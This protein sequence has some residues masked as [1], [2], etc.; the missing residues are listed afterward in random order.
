MEGY[1]K[2]DLAFSGLSAINAQA[3]V[4]LDLLIEHSMKNALVG[5]VGSKH[6][7]KVHG[8]KT[9]VHVR[10][11]KDWEMIKSHLVE[12]QN[13]QSQGGISGQVLVFLL[14]KLNTSS[15]VMSEVVL[16]DKVNTVY[17]YT[18]ILVENT[19]Y[20]VVVEV[21]VDNMDLHIEH[22]GVDMVVTDYTSEHTGHKH[23]PKFSRKRYGRV[24]SPYKYERI[25]RV[26]STRLWFKFYNFAFLKDF[27]IY[28]RVPLPNI[29]FEGVRTRDGWYMCVMP[30]DMAPMYFAAPDVD[31]L[32][33]Q[34]DALL[35][36]Y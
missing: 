22:G 3:E 16:C 24:I 13:V 35:G 32:L 17:F 20:V 9:T 8:I 21:A 10:H 14:T 19:D 26:Q 15:V 36:R 6:S 7:F 31:T 2:T 33:C 18:G 11:Q 1:M 30:E 27:E 25:L 12:T 34:Y 4:E 23:K 29:P 28:N 5:I